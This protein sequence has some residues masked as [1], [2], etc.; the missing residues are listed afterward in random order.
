MKGKIDN[1]I[2]LVGTNPLPNYVVAEYFLR[3]NNVGKIILVYSEDTNYQK[4]TGS[5]AENLKRV[6]HQRHNDLSFVFIPLSNVGYITT[7]KNDINERL[8]GKLSAIPENSHIHLNYTGGTKTMAVH[9]YSSIKDCFPQNTSFSYLDARTYKIVW[10]KDMPPSDDLRKSIEMTIDDLLKL[11]G[12]ET[13]PDQRDYSKWVDALEVFEN[14]IHE[15]KHG[16]YLSWQKD[17]LRKV[18]WDEKGFIEKTKKFLNHIEEI[19]VKEIIEDF[20]QGGRHLYFK[21]LFH[22][23]PEEHG[24]IDK[25]GSLWIP[26]NNLS[27]NDFCKRLKP[28]VKDFLDGKWLE[29]HVFEALKK[30]DWVLPNKIKITHSLKAGLKGFELDIALLYGYQLVGIS[31]T[32]ETHEG[33]CKLKAFEVLHRVN[34]IGGDESRAILV[35]CLSEDIVERFQEDI[36]IITGSKDEKFKAIGMDKLKS[37]ELS[38]E[39]REF[40]WR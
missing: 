5:F 14:I 18:Y 25:D 33:G 24:I 20:R 34:Q 23:L 17:F 32:T 31:V 28:S 9:V 12:Y 35:C 30:S 26:G 29:Y 2:L 21:E 7:I 6:L 40:I 10:D 15:G 16:K 19:A 13:E 4:G 38:E 22:S 3:E 11:H 1:L 8:I 39:I 27:N 37:E 36:R